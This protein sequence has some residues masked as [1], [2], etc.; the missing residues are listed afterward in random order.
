MTSGVEGLTTLYAVR[1]GHDWKPGGAHGG[2][3]EAKKGQF[4]AS[5]AREGMTIC[6]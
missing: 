5:R 6:G 2:R 3:Y 1:L 4:C